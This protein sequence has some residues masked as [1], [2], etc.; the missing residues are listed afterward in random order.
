MDLIVRRMILE[1]FNAD[2]HFDSHVEATR[3]V[4]RFAR[5]D[6]PGDQ[7]SRIN[8]PEHTDMNALSI[9]YQ[10]DEQGLEVQTADGHWVEAPP[11]SFT[12][13]IGETLM[14]S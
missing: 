6:P 10:H 13:L 11:Y 7:V 3:Q 9:V 12:V 2:R 14:V 5:Y 8:M 1:A 4:I